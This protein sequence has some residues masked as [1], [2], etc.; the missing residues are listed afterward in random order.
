MPN[1]IMASLMLVTVARAAPAQVLPSWNEGPAKRAIVDF[2]EAVTRDGG[3]DFVAPA[4]R[5]AVFDNDGT[6]WSEKAIAE[7]EKTGG[8]Y[9]PPT[10]IGGIRVALMP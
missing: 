6:I 9:L 5:I 10:V 3:P 1:N 4:E 8:K 7:K 2:V